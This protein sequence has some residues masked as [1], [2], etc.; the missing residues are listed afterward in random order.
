MGLFDVF[1]KKQN[2]KNDE[3]IIVPLISVNG[4]EFGTS[5]D[6][7]W[8]KIGKPKKSFKKTST[9]NTETDIYENYHIYYDNNYKFNAIEIFGKVAI[10]YNS[11]KLP[12]SYSQI[13]EF[14]KNKYDDIE[15]D[16]NGFI[17]REG[18]IGVYIENDDDNIDT[19]LFA[20]KNYYNDN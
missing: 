10:Y 5:R 8:K 3:I 18:S 9:S 15:E 7:L 13:L 1:K 2:E 12:Q 17:S 16:G 20:K 4:I 11:E 6:E 14:L 19:I